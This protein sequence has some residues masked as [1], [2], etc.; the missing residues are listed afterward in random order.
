MVHYVHKSYLLEIFFL[1]ERFDKKDYKWWWSVWEK[2]TS[3][4]RAVLLTRKKLVLLLSR[5]KL[6]GWSWASSRL[7]F[8]QM[9]I[10]D[11]RWLRLVFEFAYLNFLLFTEFT[12]WVAISTNFSLTFIRLR[13]RSW[14]RN[15]NYNVASKIIKS[16]SSK[17]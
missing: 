6:I 14:S 13:R 16:P 11:T 1:N 10:L 12:E 4:C 2:R 8:S 9:F 17:I 5:V 7:V 15:Y 3:N